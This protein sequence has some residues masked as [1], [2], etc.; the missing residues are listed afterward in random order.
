ME[1]NGLIQSKFVF[2]FRLLRF[3]GCLEGE[4]KCENED[5]CIDISQRCNRKK[6]CSDGSDEQNCGKLSKQDNLA[7]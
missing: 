3:S 5:D 2:S 7:V 6:D 1:S 4:F